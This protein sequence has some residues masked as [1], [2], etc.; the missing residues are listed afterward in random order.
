[1]S[2][3]HITLAAL[4][5]VSLVIEKLTYLH[6]KFL[7]LRKALQLRAVEGGSLCTGARPQVLCC[8]ACIRDF[9]T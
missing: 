4:L 1:M 9:E 8:E 6:S 7:S 5:F 3:C 2:D